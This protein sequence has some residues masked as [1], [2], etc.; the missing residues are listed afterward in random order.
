MIGPVPLI[1]HTSQISGKHA[2][3]CRVKSDAVDVFFVARERMQQFAATEIPNLCEVVISSRDQQ[4]P[5]RATMTG[6][7]PALVGIK[8]SRRLS[9]GR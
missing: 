5:V 6:A 4:L 8:F 3:K 9:G 2:V 7:D 1:H